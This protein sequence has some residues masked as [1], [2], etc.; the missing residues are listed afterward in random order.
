MGWPGTIA[1]Y[2]D[3]LLSKI[4]SQVHRKVASEVVSQDFFENA[5]LTGA[6]ILAGSHRNPNLDPPLPPLQKTSPP[7]NL[8]AEMRTSK[9]FPLSFS[10]FP[11]TLI[12]VSCE[13]LEKGST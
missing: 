5:A 12:S 7:C 4:T 9:R 2:G 11:P 3:N 8:L 6:T 10:G 13:H 1:E